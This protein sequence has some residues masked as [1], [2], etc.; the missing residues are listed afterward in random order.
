MCSLSLEP[1]MTSNHQ[2]CAFP[3]WGFYSCLIFAYVVSNFVCLFAA[4]IVL[5][6]IIL[7]LFLYPVGALFCCDIV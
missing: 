3:R 7:Q 5:E 1:K 6:L 4:F 2:C